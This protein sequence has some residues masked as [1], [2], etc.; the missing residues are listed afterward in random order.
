MKDPLALLKS[1][2]SCCCCIM[3]MI[4]CFCEGCIIF[5]NQNALYVTTARKLYVDCH[6][7]TLRL[8]RQE[9]KQY[10][11]DRFRAFQVTVTKKKKYKFSLCI[12]SGD[13]MY[14]VCRR[15]F[16]KAYSVSHWYVEDIINRIKKGDINCL[17]DLN[18]VYAIH[19]QNKEVIDFAEKYGIGLSHE[20]LGSLN[21]S[22]DTNILICSAWM[23]YYFQLVGDQAPNTDCEIHLEPIPKE[24]VY[25]EYVHDLEAINKEKG[26]SSDHEPVCLQTFLSIW[27]SCY[28]YVKTRKYKSSCGHCNLCTVLS[29]KRRRYRDR[30]GREEVTNLFALHRLSCM[31]ERRLYYDRREEAVRNPNMYLSTIADGMMQNHCLLPWFGNNK[32]PGAV[33]IKQHLQGVLMHGQ[34][35]TVYRTFANIGGGSNLAIHTWLLSLE[36]YFE[37]HGNRL[38]PT[39]YHQIDGGSENANEEFIAIAALLVASGLTE[40]VVLSRLP[41]GHTHEDIDGLF[42]LIWKK[43]RNENIYTP[44]E[45]AKLVCIALKRKVNVRVID[46]FCLPDYKQM[47]KDCI[48][49]HLGRLFKE[50]WTQLQVIL[51]ADNNSPMGVKCTYRA[52]AQDDFIEIVEEENYPGPDAQSISGLIPQHCKVRTRPLPSEQP[53]NILRSFP[54]GDFSPAPFIAGARELM[55]STA[56]TMIS[57]YRKSKPKVSEQWE[58]WMNNVAP[59]SDNAQEYAVNRCG[60]VPI[61]KIGGKEIKSYAVEGGG[62]YVPFRNRIF[63]MTGVSDAEIAPRPRR[64]RTDISRGIPMRIVDST[65]CV[66]HSG[67]HSAAAKSVPSRLVTRNADGSIPAEPKAAL[68]GFYGGREE[69]RKATKDRRAASKGKQ[70]SNS[71]DTR[72]KSDAPPIIP[73]T[74]PGKRA[75]NVSKSQKDDEISEESSITSDGDSESSAQMKNVARGKAL[76]IRTNKCIDKDDD[77]DDDEIASTSSDSDVENG[78]ISLFQPFDEVRNIHNLRGF[79]NAVNKDGTY[80]VTYNDGQWDKNVAHKLLRPAKR[81]G[82]PSKRK[83]SQTWTMVPVMNT[84]WNDTSKIND[85]NVIEGKRKRADSSAYR[86]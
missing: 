50:E 34:S 14:L 15:G 5:K 3:C 30:A 64:D 29:E 25:A 46:L 59:L 79:I 78:S 36:A 76:T 43:L 26:L 52:Y 31:G 62:V 17:S 57:S 71:N 85:A 4:T 20:Q 80:D 60:V 8:S 54:I 41:V 2:S 49:P 6:I 83:S 19:G 72:T 67:N 9:K 44:F 53:V 32:S 22:S 86:C 21:L 39:L 42:A 28:S 7:S 38:P 45:F 24:A 55:E 35:M 73:T 37:E 75:H 48:D 51:E 70:S 69:K 11:M 77:D 1:F 74:A 13:Q 27:K 47:L 65:T 68:N 58:D 18:P 12:G 16:A 61:L 23:K 84:T 33:H 63:G 40:K 82:K 66:L 10:L 56:T 81:E